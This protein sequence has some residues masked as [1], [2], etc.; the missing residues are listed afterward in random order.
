MI[1]FCWVYFWESRKLSRSIFLCIQITI[2]NQEKNKWNRQRKMKFNEND[3]SIKCR[4]ISKL[5]C[6]NLKQ[7]MTHE[8]DLFGWNK[9]NQNG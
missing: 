8:V 6:F 2:S 4:T 1:T 9:I 7:W 5:I 3:H